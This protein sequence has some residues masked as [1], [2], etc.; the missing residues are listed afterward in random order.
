[1]KINFLLISQYFL[2][3]AEYS[4]EQGL[5]GH[6]R[7]VSIRAKTLL[8]QQSTNKTM[9]HVWQKVFNDFQ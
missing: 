9:M 7:H 6:F 4:Y 8:M 1:M 3:Y 2:F 5:A